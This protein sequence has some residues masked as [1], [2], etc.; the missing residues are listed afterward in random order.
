MQSM[1]TDKNHALIP[2]CPL[3]DGN[4]ARDPA[5]HVA[6]PADGIGRGQ[7]DEGRF[8]QEAHGQVELLR[9]PLGRD[10]AVAGPDNVLDVQAVVLGLVAVPHADLEGVD[11]MLVCLNILIVYR[12]YLQCAPYVRYREREPV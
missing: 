11:L 3:L 1:T 6:P 10:V 12:G 2:I 8:L 5:V 7:I 4:L 9:D